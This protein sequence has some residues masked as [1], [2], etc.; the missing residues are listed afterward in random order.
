MDA[1]RAAVFQAIG[2]YDD[3]L[4]IYG[5]AAERRAD[6]H[7][8]GAL[9]VLHAERGDV[10]TAER[11]FDESRKRYRGVSPFPLALLDF[12]R[13]LMWMTAGRSPSRPYLV[14]RRASPP[15]SLCS[16]AGP[17]GRGRGCLGRA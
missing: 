4:A 15:A 3:A 6:F 5:E 13:G 1:E 12:Q 17:S 7:S 9:A 16:R 8:I 11:F 2:R 14:R 10:A